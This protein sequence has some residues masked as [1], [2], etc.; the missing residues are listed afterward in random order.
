MK[1]GHTHIHTPSKRYC[2]VCGKGMWF[3]DPD[4]FIYLFSIALWITLFLIT[5][6]LDFYTR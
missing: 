5:K 1:I 2:V 6:P 3:K 4:V